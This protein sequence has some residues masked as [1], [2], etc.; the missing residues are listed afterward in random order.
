MHQNFQKHVEVE[1]GE[2]QS[3]TVTNILC[4]VYWA[5]SAWI[6]ILK[7]ELGVDKEILHQ[8]GF[9]F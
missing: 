3:W 2:M 7:N 9:I 8:S 4:H 5:G 6:I 1:L